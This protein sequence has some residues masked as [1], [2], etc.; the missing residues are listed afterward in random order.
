MAAK[1]PREKKRVVIWAR[2]GCIV[3]D[4]DRALH[5][6]GEVFILGEESRDVFQAYIESRKTSCREHT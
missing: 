4:N 1:H 5:G 3:M 2:W 6:D